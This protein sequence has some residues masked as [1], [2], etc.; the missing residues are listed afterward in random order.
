MTAPT[1]TPDPVLHP[2]THALWVITRALWVHAPRDLAA[3]MR[4]PELGDLVVEVTAF[5]YDPDAVGWL[6]SIEWRPD[7]PGD[8]GLVA[9]WVVEPVD[10]PG[11]Q[12]G[13]RNSE[14]VAVPADRATLRRWRTP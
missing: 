4:R 10:R 8:Y 5:R 6:R 13:W 1:P 11:E 14:F 7:R 3:R 12:E 2:A 9:R